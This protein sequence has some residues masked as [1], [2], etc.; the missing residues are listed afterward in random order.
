M[1]IREGFILRETE[2]KDNVKSAIVITVGQASKVLRGYITLNETACAVWHGI[3]SGKS[4]EEIADTLCEKYFISKEQALKD[5]EILI[6]KL[7]SI[8][9]VID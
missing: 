8:G 2:S 7:K 4:V 6:E 3:E 9:A 5:A 1:K